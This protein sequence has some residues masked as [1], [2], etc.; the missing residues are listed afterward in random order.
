MQN[1][2]DTLEVTIPVQI[3]GINAIGYPTKEFFTEGRSLPW[4]QDDRDAQAWETWDIGYRDLVILDADNTP[5]HKFNLTEVNLTTADAY[6]SVL[7][8]FLDLSGTD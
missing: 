8:S 5:V 3:Y 1:E 2:L 7:Q 4:L 6:D